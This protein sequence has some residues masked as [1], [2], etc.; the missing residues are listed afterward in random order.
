[1]NANNINCIS[2]LYAYSNSIIKKLKKKH[3]ILIVNLKNPPYKF[4]LEYESANKIECFTDK[5]YNEII[6]MVNELE[7][8]YIVYYDELSFIHD[9]LESVLIPSEI[10]VFNFARNGVKEGK[11]S[12]IPCFCD[13]LNIIYTGSGAFAQS[14]CRNKFIHN[15]LLHQLGIVVP[16]TYAITPFGNWMGNSRPQ[17]LDKIIIKPIAESGSIGISDSINQYDTINEESLQFMHNQAMVLQEYIDGD[18]V[19]CP[20]FVINEKVIPLPAV[21]LEITNQPVL[22]E[23]SSSNNEYTFSLYNEEIAKTLYPLLDTIVSTLN[24]RGY[25]RI[26]FRINK[27]NEAFLFDIATMPFVCKHS[28]FS[29]AMQHLNYRSS[30]IF[31]IIL[32]IAAQQT[33]G[34]TINLDS[35]VEL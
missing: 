29:Y 27:N 26:D 7:L 34:S 1:M 21:Q 23:A 20:F 10:I 3:L 6:E 14:L 11:K 35:K 19:E 5:E 17:S 2:D 30:D 4:N 31:K 18:E 12:L 22:D 33:L 25:G 28:S 24:I 8:D 32:C 16:Q 13:L 15:K 9:V